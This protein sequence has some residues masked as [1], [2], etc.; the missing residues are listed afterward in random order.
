[1]ENKEQLFLRLFRD[2]CKAINSSR[3]LAD[4]LNL[5]T[6]N[7]IS[8]LNVKACT[9]YFWEREE[10]ILEVIATHGLS[11]SYLKKGPID[12]DISIADTLKG[13]STMIYDTT[14]DH[15]IEYPDE[16]K[17]EG[18]ASILSVPI[19]VRNKIIGVLRLYTS[20]RRNFLGDDFEFIT[21]LADMA[22]IAID[23]SRMY[24]KI[25]DYQEIMI[26]E[27]YREID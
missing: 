6:K 20:K 21:C 26:D 14:N 7:M 10:R 1:M 3:N 12:A 5:I 4:V 23:N 22:G 16:A 27:V 9:V 18:I 25:K 19:S 8:T 15:R 17:K 2:T 11:E 24:N 13:K